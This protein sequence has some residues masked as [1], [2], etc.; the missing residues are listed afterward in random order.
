MQR[1]RVSTIELVE[2]LK[3]NK[4][5][6]YDVSLLLNFGLVSTHAIS[7]RKNHIW[8]EGIDNFVIKWQSD[9]FLEHYKNARWVID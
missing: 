2:F 7:Y 1:N 6:Y 3:I 4:Y 8:D 9:D 5:L